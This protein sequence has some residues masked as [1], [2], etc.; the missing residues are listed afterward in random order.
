MRAA[1]LYSHV[2]SQIRIGDA[3]VAEHV[4]MHPTYAAPQLVT[5]G[6]STLFAQLLMHTCELASPQYSLTGTRAIASLWSVDVHTAGVYDTLVADL[7][8]SLTAKMSSPSY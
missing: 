7:A 8:S 5:S 3:L 4:A 2:L 1:A 6:L